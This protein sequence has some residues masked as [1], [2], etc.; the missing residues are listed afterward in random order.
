MRGECRREKRSDRRVGERNGPQVSAHPARISEVVLPE[1][2]TA[3]YKAYSAAKNVPIVQERGKL[4]C[5]RQDS[6]LRP[7]APEADALSN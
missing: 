5:A 1:A 7:S 6:N 2:F 4:R 3:T